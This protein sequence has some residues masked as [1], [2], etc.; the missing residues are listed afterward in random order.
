VKIRIFDK[1][2][3]HV[4][5]E[6]VSYKTNANGELE[7]VRTKTVA[8]ADPKRIAKDFVASLRIRGDITACCDGI[9]ISVQSDVSDFIEKL[10]SNGFDY[11]AEG[12]TL[13]EFADEIGASEN[14]VMSLGSKLPWSSRLKRHSIIDH[15]VAESLRDAYKASKSQRGAHLRPY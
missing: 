1:V 6:T 15:S 2:R 13:K 14:E 7:T 12:L 3:R 4:P 8:I 10:E 11:D 9:E 5:I